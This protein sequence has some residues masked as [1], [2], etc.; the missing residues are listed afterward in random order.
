M[1]QRWLFQSG[2]KFISKWVVILFGLFYFILFFL[3]VILLVIWDKSNFKVACPRKYELK[4]QFSR[5]ETVIFCL[6]FPFSFFC[7]LYW[8][9][10][11]FNFEKSKNNLMD[12]LKK[13]LCDFNRTMWNVLDHLVLHYF[14]NICANTL[15][16]QKVGQNC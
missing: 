5:M 11:M 14:P 10:V 15:V 7:F 13:V 12:M 2:G 1:G 4:R 6:F 3:L 8:L 16:T 9:L